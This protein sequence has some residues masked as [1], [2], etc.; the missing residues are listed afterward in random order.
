MSARSWASNGGTP[1]S[2]LYEA[3]EVQKEHC[4]HR[5]DLEADCM[6]ALEIM[7]SIWATKNVVTRSDSLLLYLGK[8]GNLQCPI[9]SVAH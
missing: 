7:M 5:Q 3:G 9:R 1:A 2:A 4:R 6:S 8:R